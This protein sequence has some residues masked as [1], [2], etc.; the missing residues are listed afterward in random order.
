MPPPRLQLPVP[1]PRSTLHSRQVTQVLHGITGVM[2]VNS[3]GSESVGE[4]RR[5]DKHEDEDEGGW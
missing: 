5:Q 2:G 3:I 4:R 1:R